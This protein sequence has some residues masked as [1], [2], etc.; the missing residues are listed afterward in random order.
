MQLN[1]GE[2]DFDK[3]IKKIETA[4]SKRITKSKS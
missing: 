1:A 2:S 4:N 3:A